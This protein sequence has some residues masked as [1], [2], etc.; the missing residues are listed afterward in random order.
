MTFKNGQLKAYK[1][2]EAVGITKA[3]VHAPQ[4]HAA[5]A[6]HWWSDGAGTSARFQGA[7]DDVRI[8]DRALSDEQIRLLMGMTK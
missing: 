1:D 2:A 6:R 4:Q 3:R 5:L 7:M 8:Y